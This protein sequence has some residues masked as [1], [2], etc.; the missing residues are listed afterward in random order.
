MKSMERLIG[1][2]LL[3]LVGALGLGVRLGASPQQTG[4]ADL[5]WAFPVPDKNPPPAAAETG[6]KQVAGS[7]KSYTAAQIDDLLNAVDWFP[8]EHAPM[9]SAVAHGNGGALACAVCHLAN[10]LGHPESANLAGMSADYIA[11]QM[12]DF[13]SGARKDTARMNGIAMAIS[14]ADS[15]AAAVWFASLKPKAWVRVVEADRVPK[16][17]VAAGRMRYPLP[18]GGMEPLGQRII[19]VPEDPARVALRDPHSGFIAYVPKGSVAKG[20]ALVESGGTKTTPCAYCHDDSL[21]GSGDT[22]RIAGLHPIY[23]V[24]QLYNFKTGASAGK[25]ADMMK[26]VVTPLSDEDILDI[27]AYLASVKP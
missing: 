25:D 7:T 1:A 20:E 19:T 21:H 4:G 24:R 12:A 8:D 22:P 10:G 26:G 14:D 3:I 6:T 17:W 2:G 27:A 23:I 18:G 9:P 5:T 13:K 16:T 15:R 11:G